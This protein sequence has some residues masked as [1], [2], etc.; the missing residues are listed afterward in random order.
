MKKI[1]I[2]SVLQTLIVGTTYGDTLYFKDFSGVEPNIAEGTLPVYV[3]FAQS[4]TIDPNGNAANE[5]PRL[6]AQRAALLMASVV[7]GSELGQVTA[8]V[9]DKD[10]SV[11]GE[12]PMNPPAQLPRADKEHLSPDRPD[13]AYAGNTWSV[14]LP[15]HWIVPG[16]TIALQADNGAAAT[17]DTIDV[18]APNDLLLINARF[19]LFADIPSIKGFE[20]NAARAA[21]YFQRLPVSRLVVSNYSPVYLDEV[22]LSDGTVYYH[23]SNDEGGAGSGDLRNEIARALYSAGT[24]NA[25]YGVNTSDATSSWQMNWAN[26]VH[27]FKSRGRYSNGYVT[28]GLSAMHGTAAVIDTMGNEFSHE[29]AHSYGLLGHFYGGGQLATHNEHS[30]WAW[31]AFKGQFMANFFWDRT[32]DAHSQ[33]HATPPFK[34]IYQ[35]NRDTLGGGEASSPLSV[36]TH[37]TGHTQKLLQLEMEKKSRLTASGHLKWDEASQSMVPNKERPEVPE[38]YGV[39]VVTL[40]GFFDP[41]KTLQSYIYP[42]AFGSYG[43]TYSQ[44]AVITGSCW[45][46]VA[47]DQGV[48]QFG[49]S[50]QRSQPERMNK[51]HFNVARADNPQHV[52]VFCPERDPLSGYQEYL[53]TKLGTTDFKT[54]GVPDNNGTVGDVY[55]HDDNGRVGY[56]RL[57][58]SKYWYFPAIGSSNSD[59]EFLGADDTMIPEFH[60]GKPY[61]YF[62]KTLVASRAITA[63]DVEP[64]P[65]VIIGEETGYSAIGTT[66]PTFDQ[67]SGDLKARGF[68]TLAEFNNYLK[69]HYGI[70]KI[71]HWRD[72]RKGKVGDIYHYANTYSGTQDF[73][74]LM[75]PSYGYHPTDQSSNSHWKF[76]GSADRY[77][78]NSLSPFKTSLDQSVSLKAQLLKTRNKDQVY[79]WDARQG[80]L[81]EQSLFEYQNPYNGQTEYFAQNRPQ[82]GHYFPTHGGS[83][84]HWLY[85]GSEQQHAD[86]VALIKSGLDGFNQLVAQ[87]YGTDAIRQWHE[88]GVGLIGDIYIRNHSDGKKYYYTLLQ[89]RYGTFPSEPGVSCDTWLYQGIYPL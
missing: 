16:M 20:E 19:G 55:R 65:A 27:V 51:F 38:A 36:Y 74:V 7:D 18:G 73:F 49:L 76:L 60:T 3:S 56:F 2:A 57:K 61:D 43:H 13:V 24:N 79:D 48:K 67:I 23:Q 41:Q 54:W 26:Q 29:V 40:L 39:P 68:A 5:M 59:W 58:T 52:D 10:G 53:A 1:L 88:E 75:T 37:H 63:P 34:G 77:V 82:H 50:S 30:G 22:H 46:E 15:W 86:N 35:F 8:T 9:M 64:K 78:N 31:N 83:N 81:P 45:A 80:N 87:W 66:Q 4:H 89:E 71:H 70:S 28:H 25:N 12:L 6:V 17:V 62:G 21:D 44:P 72:E 84:Q 11:L 14:Q 47:T 69:G 32:G 85:L 33:G 42:A